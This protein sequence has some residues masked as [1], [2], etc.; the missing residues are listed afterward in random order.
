MSPRAKWLLLASLYFSQGL[1]FGFF[2]Q[3]LPVLL[4]EDG[5]SLSKIGVSSLLFLPWAFKWLWAPWVDAHGT[6][7]AWILPLQAAAIV[8]ALGLAAMGQS[9]YWLKIAIVLMALL[10]ATQDLPT[11][12]LAVNLLRPKERGL[13][14]AVQVGAYRL[15]MVLGG[16]ALMIVLDRYGWAASFIA[17]AAFL[18]FALLPVVRLN[19]A[20]DLP[21][22]R[23]PALG[24]SNP[25]RG[26]G[27]RL[28]RPG[29]LA[30]LGLLCAYKFGDA[31]AS[32]MVKPLLVDLGWSKSEIGIWVGSLGSVCGLLG[33]V[34]GGFLADRYGRYRALL[35]CGLGQSA[36]VLMYAAAVAAPHWSGLMQAAIGLEHL[37]GG[38]ATVALF[39]LMMDASHDAHAGTDYSLQASAVVVAT[40]LASV[41]G[42]VLGDALGYF[43]LFVVAAGLSLLGCFALL[44]GIARGPVGYALTSTTEGFPYLPSRN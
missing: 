12:A 2:T 40:G 19:E 6:R 31:M 3:A 21:R 41:A 5:A 38:M 11:D 16:G 43:A 39:T 29:M 20:R 35:L 4:R 18:A 33:A 30:L 1:P 26:I 8:T 44:W 14:N 42:G 15:G 13:G 32:A 37:L 28:A 24:L 25:L 7:R 22:E 27:K 9:L 23:L 10:A 36:A 34:A 17:M